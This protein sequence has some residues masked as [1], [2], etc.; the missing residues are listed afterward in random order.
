MMWKAIGSSVAGTSHAASGKPCED[1]VQ[2]CVAKDVNGDEV[3][4]C[5]VSD[6]AGSAAFAGFASG[7]ATQM[8]TD[9]LRMVAFSGAAISQGDIYALAEDIYYGLA[10]AAERQ[11]VPLNEYSCT[12]LGCYITKGRAAFFQV[13]DG[14]IVRNDGTG[15]YLPVWWPENGEYQNSTCFLVDDSS[16]GNLNVVITEGAVNEVAIFTDGM[17]LLA[18]NTEQETAHQPFFTDMFR[19][20]RMA[21]D[22]EKVNVLHRKLG[23]YLDSKQINDR[24][25]DDKTLFL[26]TRIGV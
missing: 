4:I 15:F 10:A 13:G 24:T 5:C 22:H 25:D 9:G 21:N 1:A 17:Q 3:M 2:Y 11:H 8:M 23:E 6:G 7:Y 19:F 16:F 12:M 20:L 14:A 18:L 26:A